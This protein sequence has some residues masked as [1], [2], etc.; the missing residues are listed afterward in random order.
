MRRIIDFMNICLVTNRGCNLRCTH[1]YIEPE[2]LASRGGMSEE[3]FKLTYERIETLLNLDAHTS[4]IN[5]EILGGEITRMPFEFWETL[6]PYSLDK[7]QHFREVTGK[8]ASLAW[9]TNMIFQ[10]DRYFDLIL[11]HKNDTNWSVFIP[12][13][14]DTNRFGTRNKLYP[15]YLKNLERIKEAGKTLN[16][17][18]TK[19][20]V[21]MPIEDFVKV[22]RDGS[23]FDIS[24]DMLYPYGSGKAFFDEHQPTFG[25]VS[26]FYIRMTEALEKIDGITISPWDEVSGSLMTGKGFNLNGNDAYDLTIEPDGSVVLNSSMT[27]SEAPLPSQ[28][29]SL[30]DPLWNYKILFEN[31]R[32]M[33]VKF[34]VEQPECNQCEY[35]R[36]CNGGYYHY[37]YLSPEAISQYNQDDCAGY[38]KYWDYAKERLGNGVVN[39]SDINHKEMRA[40]L[41]KQRQEGYVEPHQAISESSLAVSYEDFFQNLSALSKADYVVID[42]ARRFGSTLSE[43]LWFYDGIGVEVE[44]SS[45]LLNQAGENQ[46]MR[47]ARNLASGNFRTLRLEPEVVWDYC[48]THSATRFATLVLDAVIA[49][50][51]AHG[52]IAGGAPT[53][54]P[55][56]LVIDERNDELFRFVLLNNVPK[57]IEKLAQDRSIP[58]LSRHSAD[59]IQKVRKHINFESLLRDR[60]VVHL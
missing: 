11:A 43:R 5:V 8:A 12:W 49:T 51:F 38:K 21:E 34:S 6:L 45:S 13:E 2:L 37:K 52:V 55:S 19:M 39:V 36:Y 3:N 18:P 50:R 26:D 27:G 53:I 30:D 46:W 28:S 29:I 1:C 4:L 33:E 20:L 40:Q 54:M 57:S 32:Q 44:V 25:Q 35:L 9:C 16:I 10:D 24:S 41:R 22:V 56:T 48:L 58:L 60:G 42:Q 14:P 31:I 7:H 59:A 15:R 17:I 47:I 23:F